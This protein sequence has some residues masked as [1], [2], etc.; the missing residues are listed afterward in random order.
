MLDWGGKLGL[1]AVGGWFLKRWVGERDSAAERGRAKIADVRPEVVPTGGVFTGDHRG[2]LTLINRGPGAA[3]DIRVTLADSAA[4]GRIS[5]LVSGQHRQTPEIK[6]ADSPFFSRKLGK[7]AE[8]TIKFRNRFDHEYTTV[9]LVD[10][11]DAGNN[12]FGMLPRWGQHRVT[13]PPL[14][15]KM[16]REI[17]GP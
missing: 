13:D 3:R 14:T 6:W 16:L 11:E 10:Q 7:P 17:G 5:E 1:G 8:I 15:K 9:L 2:T 12:R 4:G